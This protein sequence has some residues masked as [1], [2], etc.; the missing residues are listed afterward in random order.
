MRRLAFRTLALLEEFLLLALHKTS[1]LE[2]LPLFRADGFIHITAIT[3]VQTGALV[4]DHLM[5]ALNSALVLISRP[6]LA[7]HWRELVV[8]GAIEMR[9]LGPVEIITGPLVGKGHIGAFESAAGGVGDS[10]ISAD[11]VVDAITRAGGVGVVVL[12]GREV[13]VVGGLIGDGGDRGLDDWLGAPSVGFL[14]FSE[15]EKHA[16]VGVGLIVGGTDG[17]CSQETSGG[18]LAGDRVG[19]S[20]GPHVRPHGG[21]EREE[22]ETQCQFH[23]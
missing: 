6:I 3:G 23:L 1:I 17:G 5:T 9:R 13:S 18:G 12:V 11:R 7:A 4:L 2:S 8:A 20:A 14:L 21:G 16:D 10:V 19:D 15:Q 22:K